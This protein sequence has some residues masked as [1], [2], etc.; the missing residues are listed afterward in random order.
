MLLLG[1]L[2]LLA[3]DRA[4]VAHAAA[5]SWTGQYYNNTNLTGMPVLTRD[6]GGV[7]AVPT[8]NGTPAIDFFWT[9]SPGAGVA[10][11][12]FSVRWTRTDTFA[13]GTYRFTSITDDGMRIYVDTH[14]NGGDVLVLNAWFPQPP[15]EWFN[16]VVL[17]AGTHKITVEYYDADNAATAYLRVE[18]LNVLPAGWT[19]QYYNNTTLTGS[20]VLTRTKEP[21]P[22]F[23]WA[24]GSPAPG[25]NNNSFSARWTRTMDFQEGVYQFRTVS[26]DGARVYVDGQ[27]ILDYWVNQALTEHVANKQMTAGSH[28]VVVEYFENTG[29]AAMYFTL[30]Y[31]PDL[32]GFVTDVIADTNGAGF[33]QLPTSFAFA[34]DGRIFV[35]MKDGTVKIIQNGQLL[36]TPYYVVSPVN[37][38]GDRGLL[39]ITLDPQF[40][41]NGYVYLAYTYDN[42]PAN[43]SG[44]KTA[45]VI[46]VNASVPSGNVANGASKLVLLGS[47]VGT[48]AQPSCDDYAPTADCIPSD[49]DSHTVGNVR[50]GPDGMLYISTGDG[51]SYAAPDIRALRSQNINNLAGKVLRV[52]PANGQGLT[53]N[54]FYNGS[55]TAIRSKVYALGL[56][57]P[58]RFNFKPGTGTIFIGDVGWGLWEEQNVVFPGAN[59]GWPC[60]EGPWQLQNYQTYTTCQNLSSGSVTFALTNYAHPPDAAAVGGD[61]TGVNNYSSQYHNTYFYADYPRDEI[62]VLKVDANNNVIPGSQNLFTNAADGPVQVQVNPADGDVYYLSINT[63]E[64]RRIRYIGDNRPPVAVASANPSAGLAPLNVN[65]SSEGSNDPDAGQQITYLW[66]FG[67]GTTS[68]APNPAKVFSTNGNKAVT[69]TVT[70]PFFLPDTVA[71]VVQVGNTPPVS[72]IITPAD[73]STYDIGDLISFNG[74][75]TDLQ[76]GTI[77]PSGRAWTVKLIHCSDGTF[78]SCHDHTVLSTSGAGGSFPA[79]DHGDFTFFEI[80][81]TATDSGGLT[82]TVKHT[83]RANT[84]NLGFDSIPSGIEIAVNGTTQAA[85]FVRTVPRGST[86]AIFAVSP[87]AGLPFASWSDGGAQQHSIVAN[88]NATYTVT[89]ALPTPTPT[90]TPTA[91]PTSTVVASATPT[92]TVVAPTATGTLTS[93]PTSTI[94][95]TA[96]STACDGDIDCDGVPDEVDNCVTVPNIDQANRNSEI[97]ALPPPFTFSDH[98]NPK[99]LVLGDACNP[100][101]DNDGLTQAQETAAGTNPALADTDGDR[102]LDGAEVRCGSNPLDPA[103][104]VVG[105]DSDGDLLPD[106]CEAIIGTNPN[107]FDTDGDGI[108]DGI[109]FLRLGTNPL[110]SNTDG[111]ACSDGKEL[112]SMNADQIVNVADLGI[113]TSR[114]SLA[115]EP[116]YHWNFDL[117]RDG[118]I[119]SIDLLMVAV[120]FGPC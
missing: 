35:A 29:G 99:A 106:A 19:G 21:Y 65:F 30:D 90:R 27:L 2:L 115:G 15:T 71:I 85:P 103:S 14:N 3:P 40:A 9:G 26:D 112:A 62:S 18:N 82:N 120:F 104:R 5:G 52:N 56:R 105:L 91:T 44:L 22:A 10:A 110:S 49:Y 74:S 39:G 8:T 113:T 11:N 61:F 66:D 77:P 87:Q 58:F 25:I 4:P 37:D 89:F 84:V 38:Y 76:D 107:N 100:D 45:Q 41:T 92:P 6:D 114:Y 16:D 70:D 20:P 98:T 23:D 24:T 28:T 119:N 108:S 64:L 96:T 93:T 86:H 80:Y 102:Q 36:A 53:D 81:L 118:A 78:T 43:P 57:N 72:T 68:T 34:P 42:N 83:I 73:D 111:D 17:P 101:V 79:D 94:S 63:G 32:G 75:A 33:E 47:V 69:L 54:P 50:F 31:R 95:P 109:E 60:F 117:N 88:S 55:V 59:F 46:R 1:T 13:A 97:T 51:A 12:S 116:L 67:D 48:P 7:G